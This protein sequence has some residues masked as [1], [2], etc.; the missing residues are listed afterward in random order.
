MNYKSIYEK[1][2]Q[3]AVNRNLTTYKERHHIIPQCM[4]GTDDALNL[5]D[6]T[7]EEH[8]LAHQLLVKIHP[9]NV[10]LVYAARMMTISSPKADRSK[11]KLFGWLRRKNSEA[12]KD[13]EFSEETRKKMSISALKKP[14]VTCPY[15][16]KTGLVGN[17]N[18]WHFDNCPKGP[19]KVVHTI[20]KEQKDKISN[21]FKNKVFELVNCQFCGIEGKKSV[22]VTHQYFCK[23]N[24]NRKKKEDP[25]IKCPHC[26]KVGI[27]ANMKRWHFDN[28]KL[29][30]Q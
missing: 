7:P 1:L 24:P 8:Y 28:C 5:V 3:R 2:I 25:K 19:N 10:S 21:T 22:I 27:P 23:L 15:C 13:K 16:G 6:L 4:G 11:N 14:R 17:M 12:Q 18:R 29:K 9:D 30:P 26:D 20:P